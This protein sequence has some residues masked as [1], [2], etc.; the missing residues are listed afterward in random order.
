MNYR[1]IRLLAL[2]TAILLAVPAVY[3]AP[4]ANSH[5]YKAPAGQESRTENDWNS[6]FSSVKDAYKNFPARAAEA[7]ADLD[8]FLS[9]CG[10]AFQTIV[11]GFVKAGPDFSRAMHSVAAGIR[12]AGESF[13]NPGAHNTKH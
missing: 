2:L 13:D 6:A 9:A 12:K 8:V 11:Q 1:S 10:K 3:A 7:R 5:Y 4:V